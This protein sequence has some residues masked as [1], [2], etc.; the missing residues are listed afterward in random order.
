MLST[1]AA[2]LSSMIAMA[3]TAQNTAGATGNLDAIAAIAG[4]AQVLTSASA[5]FQQAMALAASGGATSTAAG[6]LGVEVGMSGSAALNASASGTIG[7]QS[8]MEGTATA[9]ASA[10]ASLGQ[11]VGME[12]G[13]SGHVSADGGIGQDVTLGGSAA[14]QVSAAGRLAVDVPKDGGITYAVNVATGAATTLSNFAFDRLITA[15]NRMYGI[16]NGTLYLVVGDTDPGDT[17]INATVRFAPSHY[18]AIGRKRLE[19]VYCY[20]RE[21]TGVLATPIYDEE[22]GLQYITTPLNRDGMRATRAFIGRGNSWHTLGLEIRN[23]NGGKLDIGGLEPVVSLL[24][25]RRR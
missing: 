1:A 10:S 17:A 3:T 11:S 13:A 18:G 21:L 25:R 15:H 7:A 6:S 23:I 19:T 8:P 2:Q 14:A 12:G 5:T 9:E 4:A 16:V 20:S 22:T 24:S